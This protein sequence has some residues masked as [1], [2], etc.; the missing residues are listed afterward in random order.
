MNPVQRS[1]AIEYYNMW[2][3]GYNIHVLLELRNMVF[4]PWTSYRLQY[5]L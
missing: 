5:S 1:F 2:N 4:W 3:L